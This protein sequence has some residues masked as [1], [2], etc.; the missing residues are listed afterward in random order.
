MAHIVPRP[1]ATLIL[2]RDGDA[3]P[4]IFMLKRSPSAAFVANAYVFPGGG[5]D[6]ADHKALDRVTGLT[7][8]DANRRLGVDAG[9]LAYWV[10]A[11]RECFEEAGI[12]IATHESGEPLDPERANALAVHREAVNA[13]TLAFGELLAREKLAIPAERIA[14]FSHWVTAPGRPR[15]FSARF[16]VA[17]A[18]EGQH[19][20]HDQGETVASE[21]VRPHLALER[22]S[23]GE[24]ELVHPTRISLTEMAAFERAD[25][26]FEFASNR[27]DIEADASC[28]ATGREGRKLFRRN[29]TP[30]AEI[31]WSDPE[32]AGDTS[33][34]LVPGVAKRLDRHVTRIIAPNPGMMTGPGTNTYLVGADELAVIDPGPDIDSHVEAILAAGAGRIKWVLCTHTH[35]DHSPAAKRIKAAT[36]AT[37]MGRPAPQGTSQD[38]AFAPD[39]VLEHGEVLKCGPVSLRAIHTPGHAS[40]HLCYLLEDTRMLFTGDHV[41]QGSTVVIN[42]PDGNMLAYFASL[43]LLLAEDL[44]ILAP[45]HGYLLGL[46]HKE[47]RRL[48]AHRLGREEKVVAALRKLGTANLEELVPVVYADVPPKLHPVASRSLSAHLEKLVTE[49]KALLHSGRWSLPA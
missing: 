36:G 13:G 35:M 45:G 49:Q 1:A 10:A 43:E 3:G 48:I 9:G 25:A 32:E 30:Y 20:S 17:R 31:H 22:C 19:G 26:A 7:E 41:M 12:L 38:L 23:K 29:D 18:P 14:Y 15:R 5:L 21:W 11:V 16:F 44:A 39:R 42:P 28:W 34:D 37:V 2:L 4:E 33:Y 27:V 46:P 8:A 24:I 6:A 40:N 47:V